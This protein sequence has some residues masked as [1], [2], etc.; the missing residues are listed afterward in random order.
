M[1]V[2]SG[3][4]REEK[5]KKK[6]CV[7]EG[8]G[9]AEGEKR[10]CADQKKSCSEL[11][12]QNFVFVYSLWCALCDGFFQSL[13]RVLRLRICPAHKAAHWPTMTML[14]ASVTLGTHYSLTTR[15]VKVGD[16]PVTTPVH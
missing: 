5:K 7:G 2:I 16:C 4:L 14:C 9:G 6:K 11:N 15:R 13:T 12:Q 1:N 3:R 8:G 10:I